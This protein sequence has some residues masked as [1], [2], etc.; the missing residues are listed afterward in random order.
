VWSQ[1]AGHVIV[2]PP[3]AAE[4]AGRFRRRSAARRWGGHGVARGR[5]GHCCYGELCF[6]V[7]WARILFGG[8]L[9]DRGIWWMEGLALMKLLSE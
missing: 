5:R 3:A 8:T 2:R 9:V 6:G 4:E 7:F 1:C